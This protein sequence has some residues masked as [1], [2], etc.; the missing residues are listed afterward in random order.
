MTRFVRRLQELL[1]VRLSFGSIFIFLTLVIAPFSALSKET[2]VGLVWKHK[3]PKHDRAII[4]VHGLN[5]DGMK[6]WSDGARNWLD[7]IQLEGFRKEKSPFRNVDVGTFYYES[8]RNNPIL[9]IQDIAK[10]ALSLLK[11]RNV[12]KYKKIDFVA[13]S[14]GGV[15][16][17]TMLIG[18][19]DLV[20]NKKIVLHLFGV[21]ARGKQLGNVA[22]YGVWLAVKAGLVKVT[23]VKRQL[24]SPD[25]DLFSLVSLFWESID[26][27]VSVHCYFEGK[28]T[29]INIEGLKINDL[30][31]SRST[32]DS[33][34][35]S[36]EVL[37]GKDHYSMVKP[38]GTDDVIFQVF[39]KNYISSPAK[40]RRTKESPLSK[41]VYLDVVPKK[42]STVDIFP[43]G[44]KIDYAVGGRRLAAGKY[45]VLVKR[46]GRSQ[47]DMIDVADGAVRRV[48]QLEEKRSLEG[49]SICLYGDGSGTLVQISG[50]SFVGKDRKSGLI[51]LGASTTTCR[52]TI[53]LKPGRYT[54]TAKKGSKSFFDSVVVKDRVEVIRVI[55][56]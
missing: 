6:T 4:F 33:D 5:G 30:I 26:P 25:G 1:S 39:E 37:N 46:D 2:P 40:K 19:Q 35:D 16:L 17:R 47:V 51:K 49:G 56:D 15:V 45:A 41:M 48:Y 8:G 10:S 13:H 53:A 44:K 29:V 7:M 28:K 42:G 24:V 23:D 12:D 32:A 34:C 52:G 18:N 54:I 50:P 14:L 3:V 36:K 27:Y 31:V 38:I 22:K 20:R 9:K 55:F 43:L 11:A 21:P